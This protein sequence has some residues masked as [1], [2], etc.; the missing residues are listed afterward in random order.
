MESGKHVYRFLANLII[1]AVVTLIF[2]YGWLRWLNILLDRPFL[3]LGQLTM[4][5]IY[6]IISIFFI[7]S[8]GGYEIGVSRIS[9]AS[10]GCA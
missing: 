5:I 10:I 8:F 1:T 3:G 4:V 6:M 2:A 9:H 7:Y